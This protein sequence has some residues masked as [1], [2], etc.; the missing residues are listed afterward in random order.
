MEFNDKH[1][2][3]LFFIKDQR[4]KNGTCSFQDAASKFG[5]ALVMEL[6]T[7]HSFITYDG[8][9]PLGLKWSDIA[10]QV[11]TPDPKMMSWFA[12]A[13]FKRGTIKPTMF[14]PIS[15]CDERLSDVEELLNNGF[16]SKNIPT[17]EQAESAI[18]GQGV[19]LHSK[20]NF[21]WAR[22]TNRVEFPINSGIVTYSAEVVDD[23]ME[24][25]GIKKGET[26]SF[27]PAHIFDILD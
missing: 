19:K 10:E 15:F 22:I 21:F 26:L 2:Q 16:V 18:V 5:D 9:K 17:E 13:G 12:P 8:K 1:I 25:L 3:L 23:H 27:C 20:D 14:S 7:D 11:F 4:A 6:M 24:Q